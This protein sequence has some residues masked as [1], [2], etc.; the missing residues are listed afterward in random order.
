ML[1]TKQK[2]AELNAKHTGQSIERITAD[3]DRD[4]WFTAQEALDYGFVDHVVAAA[5]MVSGSGG[6]GA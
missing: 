2:M 1:Y 6:T 5:T 4:R 3:S